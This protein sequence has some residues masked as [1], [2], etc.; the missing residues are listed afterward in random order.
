MPH[1]DADRFLQGQIGTCVNISKGGKIAILTPLLN[2]HPYLT[3]IIF[4]SI[5]FQRALKARC[6]DLQFELNTKIRNIQRARGIHIVEHDLPIGIHRQRA[7]IINFYFGTKLVNW[8]GK[9]EVQRPIGDF[10][11]ILTKT[12][13]VPIVSG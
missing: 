5:E 2:P 1:A 9:N 7:T 12:L 13:G 4:T 6:F 11:L 8:I 3:C 10:H